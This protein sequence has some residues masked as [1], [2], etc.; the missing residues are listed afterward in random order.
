ML[1]TVNI[2]TLTYYDSKVSRFAN[3]FPTNRFCLFCRLTLCRSPSSEFTH[4]PCQ[5]KKAARTTE[6]NSGHTHDFLFAQLL[7]YARDT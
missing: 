7:N 3:M 4:I 1:N 6:L 5:N 2:S